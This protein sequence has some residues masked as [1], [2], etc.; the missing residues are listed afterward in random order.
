MENLL[1]Q[2]N[3]VWLDARLKTV[4]N[5]GLRWLRVVN[6]RCSG[7]REGKGL[8]LLY[9]QRAVRSVVGVRSMELF[10]KGMK[11]RVL[12]CEN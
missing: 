10:C 5:S 6:Q 1:V 11:S 8:L 7:E 4:L 3:T 2:Q 12:C 9:E